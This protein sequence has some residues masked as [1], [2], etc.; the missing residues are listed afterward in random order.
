LLPAFKDRR[1]MKID[2]KPI[3]LVY[4]PLNLPDAT[5]FIEIWNKLA[6]ENGLNEFYFIGQTSDINERDQILMLGFNSVNLIRIFDFI[7][8]RSIIKKVFERLMVN[9]LKKPKT[10]YYS[11]VSKFFSGD[12]DSDENTI[13]TLFPNWDHSPRSGNEGVVLH[14]SRP[15]YFEKH[16][17]DV[18]QKVKAKIPQKRIVFIK[19]WN[20]WAEGNYLEPDLKFGKGYLEVIKKCLKNY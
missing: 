5:N 14:D 3:F 10:Y 19:S 20:E 11:K 1:Y 17:L 18:F 13:P 7:K 2:N 6:L 4:K 8:R 16:V 15:Q 9:I 12:E